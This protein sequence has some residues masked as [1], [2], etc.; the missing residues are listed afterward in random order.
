MSTTAGIGRR[1]SITTKDASPSVRE[2]PMRIPSATPH[3]IATAS[4]WA[5]RSSVEPISLDSVPDESSLPSARNVS[6]GR[7]ML[8]SRPSRRVTS[9]TTIARNPTNSQPG[10]FARP[11]A[12][13]ARSTSDDRVRSLQAHHSGAY[14]RARFTF[15]QPAARSAPVDLVQ[16]DR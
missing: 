7:A 12:W 16:L 3:T 4:P 1:N 8:S 2:L 9:S 14:Y 10:R 11:T 6:D 5:K 13:R 15:G